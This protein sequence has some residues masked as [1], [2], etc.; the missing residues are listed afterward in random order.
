[1]FKI[2]TLVQIKNTSTGSCDGATGVIMERGL[3]HDGNWK[4]RI[5]FFNGH[6]SWWTDT[7]LEVLCSK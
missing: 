1:M 5:L 4:Y 2:G 6:K 7:Y 3:H